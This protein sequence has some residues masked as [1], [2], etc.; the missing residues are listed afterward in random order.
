MELDDSK[1]R[2]RLADAFEALGDLEYMLRGD[3]E[4]YEK[5]VLSI[6]DEKTMPNDIGKLI[7]VCLRNGYEVKA[8]Q[9]VVNHLL[10][11]LE[12]YDVDPKIPQNFIEEFWDDAEWGS[13]IPNAALA[14]K[15]LAGC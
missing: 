4:S 10:R 14:G 2:R 1:L 13:I 12:K 6:C 11:L 9:D 8:V 3:T 7:G 15:L 5:L